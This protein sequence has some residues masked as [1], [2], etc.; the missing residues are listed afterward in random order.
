MDNPTAALVRQAIAAAYRALCD[1]KGIDEITRVLDAALEGVVDPIV[2]KVRVMFKRLVEQR[3]AQGLAVAQ[4]SYTV[5]KS[6][7]R[8]P[9]PVGEMREKFLK[10]ATDKPDGNEPD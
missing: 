1:G 5:E 9:P 4:E 7:L 10:Q 3:D 6:N 8:L 2:E